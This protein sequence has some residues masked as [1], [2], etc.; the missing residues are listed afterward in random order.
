VGSIERQSKTFERIVRLRR[1]EREHPENA[2]IVAVRA[3]LERE[4][5]GAVS[6]ALAARLLGVSHTALR[7]WVEAGDV[8]T[9]I[10]AAGHTRVPVRALADLVERVDEQ[11]RSGSRRLHLLEPALSDDRRKAERLEPRVLVDVRDDVARY[12]RAGLRSLAYHRAVARRLRRPMVDEA[13]HRI[14]EWRADGRIHERYA[15]AWETLL[16]RPIP[17][18]KRLLVEDTRA[19]ADL[20]Q[21]SPFAGML[22]EAERRK[23]LEQIR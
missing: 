14:W 22:S 5:G 4:L 12:D 21:T 17:E 23:I 3:D 15:D 13:R 1:A 11:R 19:A 7:R 2:D 9:V 18:I 16:R 6:R 8:P 10:D 20:R